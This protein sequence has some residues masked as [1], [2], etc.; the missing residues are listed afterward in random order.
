MKIE[1]VSNKGYLITEFE[2]ESNPFKVGE[3]ISLSVSNYDKE[4][5]NKKELKSDY[6]ITRIEHFIKEEYMPNEKYK[7][8]YCASV[9]V[10]QIK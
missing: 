5:W 3:V 1:I 8:H 10:T 4:F 7:L 2:L 9:E 6:R